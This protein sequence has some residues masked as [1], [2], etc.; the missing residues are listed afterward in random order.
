MAGVG[1]WMAALG[2]MGRGGDPPMAQMAPEC[3]RFPIKMRLRIYVD[4]G[5]VDSEPS[6]PIGAAAAHLSQ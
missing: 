5:Q 3:L 4:S 6:V 2:I 1:G